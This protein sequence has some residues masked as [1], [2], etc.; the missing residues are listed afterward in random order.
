[1]TRKTLTLNE[2][3]NPNRLSQ[4]SRNDTAHLLILVIAMYHQTYARDTET[5]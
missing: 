3:R 1:M 2:Q 5:D 4:A